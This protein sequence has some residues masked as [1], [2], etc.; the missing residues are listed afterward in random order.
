MQRRSRKRM[1]YSVLVVLAWFGFAVDGTKALFSDSAT[2]TSSTMATGTVDLLISNSQNSSSTIYEEERPG[3]NAQLSPGETQESYFL[4]KNTGTSSVDLDISVKSV[5]KT[6]VQDLPQSTTLKFTPVDST[7]ASIG[8]EV[9]DSVSA[10]SVS[11]LPLK[12]TIPAGGYQRFRLKTSLAS[13]Y[14]QQNKSIS[15]DLI[16]TGVQHLL[17]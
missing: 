16:F 5:V 7:G 11:T 17:P 2:L 10:L 8:E 14:T 1:I 13:S 12:V 3:F 15:Y 4:L 9:S 6:S